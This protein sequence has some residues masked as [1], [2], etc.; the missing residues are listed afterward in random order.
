MIVL[1]LEVMKNLVEGGVD[2]LKVW[3][4]GGGVDGSILKSIL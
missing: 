1:I 3:L 2:I 4:K